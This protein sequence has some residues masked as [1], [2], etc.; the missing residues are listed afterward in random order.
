[1]IN[2]LLKIKHHVPFLWRAIEHVNI[3]LFLLLHGK[4]VAS[5]SQDCLALYQL[6]GFTF[7]KLQ[8]EDISALSAFLT[9]Q[10]EER[11]EFFRPHGF[12]LESVAHKAQDPSFLM[13]G[14]FREQELVGYFF[15]RCFWN[16]KSFIGR[17]LDKDWEG[18]GI[19]RTMN[20]I[21]YNTAWNSR[22]QCLTTISKDNIAVIRSHANNPSSFVVRN[23]AN[24]YML[25][26]MVSPES[27]SSMARKQ[28]RI[29]VR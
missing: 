2:L 10:P 1:M 6:A 16:R 7:R 28:V 8:A 19:G 14:A 17:I 24:G 3:V 20:L 15:L 23:L 9:R 22:F 21:L 25:I 29:K 27:V 18:K 11:V 4:R 26:E 5:K 12:D 13:F